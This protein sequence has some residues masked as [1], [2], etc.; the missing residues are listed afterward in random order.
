MT[1]LTSTTCIK[2]RLLSS[3]GADGLDAADPVLFSP[4]AFYRLMKVYD[5]N[6]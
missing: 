5:I 2:V 1:K 6:A 3:K 4:L